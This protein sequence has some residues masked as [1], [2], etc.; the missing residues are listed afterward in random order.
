MS[1][2][3]G[4]NDQQ[5]LSLYSFIINELLPARDVRPIIARYFKMLEWLNFGSGRE[6]VSKLYDLSSNWFILDIVN[7]FIQIEIV[8]IHISP[9]CS[10][11]SKIPDRYLSNPQ[12]VPSLPTEWISPHNNLSIRVS[13]VNHSRGTLESSKPI[14]FCTMM[15]YNISLR[16]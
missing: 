10:V 13:M 4:K 1:Y 3:E 9:K 14:M 8:N 7:N 15:K 16:N 11:P 6:A 5:L 2:Y 12:I